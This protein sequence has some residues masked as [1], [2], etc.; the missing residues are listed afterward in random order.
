MLQAVREQGQATWANA[1]N[2][3]SSTSA[4]PGTTAASVCD[5]TEHYKLRF[6]RLEQLHD[7]LVA[8]SV[9]RLYA[10]LESER[11][12]IEQW[13]TREN[14]HCE[15]MLE[16]TELLFQLKCVCVCFFRALIAASFASH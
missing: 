16:R 3:I 13:A 10:L 9:L 11:V 6:R 15:E 14:A 12:F 7:Q 4:V 8:R 2:A 1:L 5:R